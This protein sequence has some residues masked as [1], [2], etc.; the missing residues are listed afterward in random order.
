MT[1]YDDAGEA[2]ADAL[3]PSVLLEDMIAR[4]AQSTRAV[5]DRMGETGVRA[6]DGV[7]VHADTVARQSVQ[8]RLFLGGLVHNR[9]VRRA[10]R[11]LGLW[12]RHVMAPQR[13]LTGSGPAKAAGSAQEE[14]SLVVED[15]FVGGG[16]SSVQSRDHDGGAAL[17]NDVEDFGIRFQRARSRDGMFA[18][19]Q[20]MLAVQGS[21]V[22]EVGHHVSVVVDQE[23]FE[24][25]NHSK[26]RHGL[27]G[28]GVFENE[29]EV[30]PLGAD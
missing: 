23:W 29:V 14:R 1:G 4:D 7:D 17:V 8:G 22:G 16:V 5:K 6:E 24:R 21:A 10:R 15:V 11:W 13:A 18:D 20:V 12:C 9:H 3:V 26:D 19:F 30:V 28:G 27:E 25:G 2:V